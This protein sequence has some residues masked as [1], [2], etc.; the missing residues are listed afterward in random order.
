MA[1]SNEEFG[2]TKQWLGL[3]ND[4]AEQ[5]KLVAKEKAIEEAEAQAEEAKAQGKPYDPPPPPVATISLIVGRTIAIVYGGVIVLLAMTGAALGL[6]VSFGIPSPLTAAIISGCISAYINVTAFWSAAPQLIDDIFIT[7]KFFKKITN[8]KQQKEFISWYR[9]AALFLMSFLFA[10]IAAGVAITSELNAMTMAGGALQALG[11]GTL[12]GMGGVIVPILLCVGFM[13]YWILY[14]D[15]SSKIL[16][17]TNFKDNLKQKIRY[18]FCIDVDKSL[19]LSGENEEKAWLRVRALIRLIIFIAVVAAIIFATWGFGVAGVGLMLSLLQVGGGVTPAIIANTILPLVAT[20]VMGLWAASVNFKLI[21]LIVLG[22]KYTGNQY[23]WPIADIES[24]GTR[25]FVALLGTV[26]LILPAILAIR[27][28]IGFLKA[29]GRYA[30]AG[31]K[32]FARVLK[33]GPG[34]SYNSVYEDA[35]LKTAYKPWS[36]LGN[37]SYNLVMGARNIIGNTALA[38]LSSPLLLDAIPPIRWFVTAPLAGLNKFLGCNR[39]VLAAVNALNNA[40]LIG[41]GEA[42]PLQVG[43]TVIPGAAVK[44]INV[45][46]GGMTSAGFGY[47]GVSSDELFGKHDEKQTNEKPKNS[48]A[49]TSPV[50]HHST[51]LAQ[52]QHKAARTQVE[53]KPVPR[54]TYQSHIRSTIPHG[55]VREE[56][57]TLPGKGPSRTVN[58][59]LK[60]G[61]DRSVAIAKAQACVVS[62]YKPGTIIT[63]NGDNYQL[64]EDAFK[65]CLANNIMFKEPTSPN[66]IKALGKARGSFIGDEYKLKGY[67]TAQPKSYPYT[68]K[69]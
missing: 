54:Y 48:A 57:H 3:I 18:L 7:R 45:S 4:Q 63:I 22:L 61:E 19:L 53:E 51:R 16:R 28:F 38:I 66:G 49:T 14:S 5:E 46:G 32:E 2:W 25:R 27:G 31:L 9:G 11:I 44:A 1:N 47:S 10:S 36:G 59:D 41:G 52:G 29:E 30:V 60:A 20:T 42:K 15:A 67:S 39:K 62:A 55:Q 12:F 43:S 64:V 34:F 58:T 6:F 24:A 56:T 17:E 26:T 8:D 21:T 33:E 50:L 68:N 69:Q 13:T 40:A 37:I 65:V 23:M 35:R